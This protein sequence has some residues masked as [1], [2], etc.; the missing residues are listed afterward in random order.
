[1]S[2]SEAIPADEKKIY[3][4]LSLCKKAGKCKS[5]ELQLLES[6][7]AEEAKLV[8]IAQDASENSK[9]RLRDKCDYRRIPWRMFGDREKLGEAIGVGERAGVA[10]T[11]AGFAKA[12]LERMDAA[13]KGE[14]NGK[15][16]NF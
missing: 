2:S 4:L 5:G 8:L 15:D 3:G 9:K 10:V 13:R 11:D 12:V 6:I 1:M 16:Q 14:S 7:K